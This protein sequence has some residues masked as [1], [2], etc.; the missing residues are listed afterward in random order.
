M[1]SKVGKLISEEQTDS[2]KESGSEQYYLDNILFM[3]NIT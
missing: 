3:N 2:F 1:L